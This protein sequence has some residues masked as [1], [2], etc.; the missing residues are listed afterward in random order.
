M[1][2]KIS[3]KKEKEFL[4]YA[5]QTGFG[6][7][8]F[9]KDH[10][11]SFIDLFNDLPDP[12]RLYRVIYLKSKNDFDRDRPGSHYVLNKEKLIRDHY[13]SM[14]YDYSKFD[15]SKAYIISVMAN[16]NKIDFD[17]TIKNNLAYPHEEEITLK[18][19]GRGVNTI[20][21]ERFRR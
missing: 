17:E 4:T 14:L 20:S 2:Y 7:K 1:G 13:D 19:K 9:A 12:I 15:E 8:D 18:D 6:D 5:L 11:K 3:K 21:I 10:L 16:K